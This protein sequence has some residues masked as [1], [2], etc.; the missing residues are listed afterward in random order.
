MP[1]KDSF[2]N[3]EVVHLLVEEE[4]INKVANLEHNLE[5]RLGITKNAETAK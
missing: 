4:R 1:I 3:R 2:S 5:E